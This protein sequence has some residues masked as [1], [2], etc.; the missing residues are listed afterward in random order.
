[1]VRNAGRIHRTT[2]FPWHTSRAVAESSAP[3]RG[4]W[5]HLGCALGILAA[6]LLF[7]VALR[8]IFA[9][10][11][12]PPAAIRTIRNYT[13]GISVAH[14]EADGL[15]QLGNRLTGNPPML[16]APEGLIVGD[17]HVAAQAVRD[18]ETMGAIIERLSR[19]AGHPLNVR[20]YGW[21]SANAPT[22]LAAAESL[23]HRRNPAWIAVVLNAYNIG[24]PALTA[25][26]NWRMEL[27]PGNSFRLIEAR[28]R[29]SS[30]WRTTA[31]QWVAHS[32]LA[33]ALAMRLGLIRSQRAANAI[34]QKSALGVDQSAGVPRATVLGLK[35]A[36]GA[37][38]LIVFTPSLLGPGHSDVEATE[39]EVLRLCAEEHVACISVRGALE[40]DRNDH[41]RLSRGFHNTA[42]GLGH[43][44]AI[45]H[46]IIGQEIWRYLAVHAPAPL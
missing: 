16:G 13:E 9:D 21:P 5:R 25:T 20:Q 15:G 30:A 43:F 17:S 18:E 14:F 32:T 8:A 10:W 29:P 37:R 26:G 4:A 35:E 36:Y 42:P 34:A 24:A 31:R 44:N 19:T 39:T 27:G 1:M 46:R 33:M 45:G 23:L 40:Q 2:M 41:L 38:L 22:F 12:Y 11:N 7:E 6:A 3:R 28:P